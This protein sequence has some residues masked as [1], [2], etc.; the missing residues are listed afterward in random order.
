MN[1]SSVV[2]RNRQG[3]E[4]SLRLHLSARPISR[5][6]G[7]YLSGL[8]DSDDPLVRDQR[9][10]E[11]NRFAAVVLCNDHRFLI[12]GQTF[13]SV[14]RALADSWGPIPTLI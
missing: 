5:R 9:F 8:V 11:A 1:R 7:C 2:A 12:Y 4:K 13:F 14:R 10:D 3:P 6:D